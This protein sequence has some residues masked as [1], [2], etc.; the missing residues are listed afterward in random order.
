MR[1]II[2]TYFDEA[3][4]LL[5]SITV[6]LGK[7]QANLFKGIAESCRLIKKVSSEGHKII[8]IGNGGSAAIASHMAIDFWK[9]GGIKAMAFN[10]GAQLTCLGNDFGY[11]RVFE[12]PIEMF[13]E[14]GDLL[15]AISSSGQSPNILKAVKTAKKRGCRIIT[16]SGFKSNNPLRILGAVNFFVPSANY[17]PVEVLHQFICHYILDVCILARRR[18][19]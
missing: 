8:F 19:H 14:K 10:D 11:E 4:Q 16:L 2:E 3:R 1:E 18:H 9:N 5:S 7:R 6:R 13:A 15:I 12:K 17:G